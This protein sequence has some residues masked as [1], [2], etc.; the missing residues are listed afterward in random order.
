[1][2]LE[3][4]QSLLCRLLTNLG[5]VYVK[6]GQTLSARPDVVGDNTAA[7]LSKLQVR[8]AV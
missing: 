7:A 6:L 4:E 5:P 8:E 3:A 1:L 2:S